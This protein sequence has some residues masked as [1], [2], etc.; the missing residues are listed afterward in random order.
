M[1]QTK[2]KQQ[3]YGF[4]VCCVWSI[5]PVAVTLVFAQKLWPLAEAHK[6]CAI[7]D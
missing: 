6:S 2:K 7:V 4:F 1:Q 3:K 5:L